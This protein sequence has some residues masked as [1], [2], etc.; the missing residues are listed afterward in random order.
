[1]FAGALSL[2]GHYRGAGAPVAIEIAMPN[3]YM[4]GLGGFELL[5]RVAAAGVFFNS[6]ERAN[7]PAHSNQQDHELEFWVERRGS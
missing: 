5:Q 3:S 4:D 2:E 6:G 1:M 7:P